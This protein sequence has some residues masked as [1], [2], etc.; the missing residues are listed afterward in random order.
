MDAYKRV[1]AIIDTNAL[2]K[3]Y[4][5]IRKAADSSA[6][7]MGIIKADA[8][9]HG[10]IEAAEVLL[11][12][13]CRNF[14][15]A[16]PEEGVRLRENGVSV[17]ILVLGNTFPEYYDDVV[18]YDLTQTICSF[19]YAKKLSEAARK[20][21]KT[22]K[23]HIKLDTGMGRIGFFADE[24]SADEIKKI[25][26]LDNIEIEGMY[27]HFALADAKDK[28]YTALQQKR[29]DR[30]TG[31]LL[32]KGIKIPV[33]HWSNSAAIMDLSGH[34]GDIVRAG[35][36][37]YG[38]YPSDEVMKENLALY[39]V[40]S[41]KS[42]IAFLKDIPAGEA[43]SYGCTYKAPGARKIA[44]IPV[45]YADGYS[46]LLSNKGRVI[47]NGRYAPIVGRVCMDQFMADVT[48]IPGTYLGQEVCLMGRQ[49]DAEITADELADLMGTINY[50][51]TCLVSKRVPRIYE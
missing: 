44:T 17:P 27:T 15:V 23:I 28:T 2:A 12:N 14:G 10:D 8:Y 1:A 25:S 24:A 35:I 13:G 22:A 31:L 43:V 3:N 34:H 38:L 21:N 16:I 18:H 42:R 9:G 41:I 11:Q 32:A 29:F 50:E 20:Q 51:V 36:I 37:L 46:R 48:N 30:M 26:S 47:I 7:V 6:D 40:M 19:E 45:G 33:K 39:P 4:M 5:N 49:G